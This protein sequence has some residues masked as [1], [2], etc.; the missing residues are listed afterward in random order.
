MMQRGS[1]SPINSAELQ[2]VHFLKFWAVDG[3]RFALQGGK[4]Q[5]SASGKRVSVSACGL[6][7]FVPVV[8]ATTPPCAEQPKFTADAKGV[9]L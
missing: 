9:R 3:F 2:Q 4:V 7:V 6:F 8:H 1:A 5:K